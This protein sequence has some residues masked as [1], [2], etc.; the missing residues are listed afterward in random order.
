MVAGGWWMK[1]GLSAAPSSSTTSSASPSVSFFIS[2]RV[3]L[4]RCSHDMTA[5]LSARPHRAGP[6]WAVPSARAGGEGEDVIRRALRR[7]PPGN[8]SS[9]PL[10]A[11]EVQ[12]A[13]NWRAYYAAFL[14]K[15]IW[16]K[17]RAIRCIW[18]WCTLTLALI[19]PTMFY[20]WEICSFI[21]GN[22]PSHLA[23]SH[24]NSATSIYLPPPSPPHSRKQQSGGDLI[25]GY[26]ISISI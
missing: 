8:P 3:S 25:Y 18:L 24:V 7:E 19:F 23:R 21:Q 26:D 12:R 20:P 9:S 2:W 17:T 10:K 15:N 16:T 4:H 14:R 13:L 22:G 11:E 1:G 5:L 6:R